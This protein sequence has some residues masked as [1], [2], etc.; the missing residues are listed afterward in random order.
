MGDRKRV[1][2]I[3][4]PIA[5]IGGK[6]G[7][8]GSDGE[9]I[10]KKALEKGVRP[11]AP[12][13]AEV[14]LQMLDDLKDQIE[15]L[16]YEGKMGQETAEACGFSVRIMGKGRN[17]N[18]TVSEDTEDLAAILLREKADLIL[19][20]GGDGTARNLYKFVEEHIP[21]IGIPAGVKIHSAVY[22]VNPKAAGRA[23]RQ[24]LSGELT[25]TKTAEVMDLDENLYRQGIISPQLYGY[26]LV[27]D[28]QKNMQN[29][30]MRSVCQTVS[31][32]YIAT[33]VIQSMEKD[34]VYLIGAGTTTRN[35]MILLG[36]DYTLIGVDAVYNR[37]L[38]GKD[39]DEKQL[40]E[41]IKDR[42][43]SLILTAIGGQGH[44]F[45]RGNQQISPRI[46]R[47]AGKENIHIVATREKLLSLPERRLLTDTGDVK[48]DEELCGYVQV[49]TGLNERTIC[50]VGRP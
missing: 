18:K 36:L 29:V 41:M 47:K 37:A 38:L 17:L 19:F 13:R 7:L 42:P 4:N 35:I 12:A 20:A 3:I 22:A 46:I 15:I 6:A 8:K 28:N 2:L 5:G 49:I 44:I 25:G 31:L 23:A 33:D 32:D 10:Q 21:V 40:W 30:K 14:A 26:M 50:P 43:C 24:F 45:G 48:L 9:T 1:G 11:E 34:T 16:T 27:P 39:L